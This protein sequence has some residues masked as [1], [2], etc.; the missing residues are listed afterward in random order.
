[1]LTSKERIYLQYQPNEEALSQLLHWQKRATQANPQG[2]PVQQDRLHVTVIHFGIAAD[3]FR[4]LSQQNSK[5]IWSDFTKSAKQFIETSEAAL[6]AEVAVQPTKLEF[7]GY[8]SSVLALTVMPDQA[9]IQAHKAALANLNSFLKSCGIS[10]PVPFMQGSLNLRYA[11]TLS[12]HIS[13]IKAARHI[14]DDFPSSL[15]ELQF[16]VMPV[17]YS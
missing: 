2:R 3:V 6:P 17:R 16:K 10:Y 15:P 7:F 5:L 8:R 13:L 12:P 11:L 9:L 1:M 14:P 4:E